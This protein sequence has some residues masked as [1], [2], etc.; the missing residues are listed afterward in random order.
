LESNQGYVRRN[1]EEPG[2]LIK[3]VGVP[4]KRRADDIMMIV[5]EAIGVIKSLSLESIH[6]Q[7]I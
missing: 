6:C 2:D 3:D 4:W 5:E 1:R 7:F